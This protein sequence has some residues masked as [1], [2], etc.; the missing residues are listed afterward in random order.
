MPIQR[1]TN[2]SP[3]FDDFAT[4]KN[5]YRVMF[6]PGYPVQAREL[7]QSQSIINDQVEQFMSRLFNE[8]DTI[9]PGSFKYG[10]ITPYVRVSALTL[11]LIH[12]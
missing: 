9:V 2:I 5:F 3:Y 7:T 10:G 1:N 4:S 8:G 6:K 12:I 11:S